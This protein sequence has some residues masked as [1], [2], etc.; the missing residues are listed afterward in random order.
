MGEPTDLYPDVFEELSARRRAGERV[1]LATVVSTRG[2][3]PRQAGAR[4]L[5]LADGSI[6]GTVGGGVRESEIAAVARELHHRGG[7]RLLAVDFEE[8]LAGGPAPV[9]GGHMEVFVEAI[10][11]LLR[12]VIA[13]AGHVGYFLHRMLALLEVRTVVV[14]P[15]AEFA[16]RER[17]P[18]AELRVVEFG[19]ALAGLALG[20]SDGVVIVT[21]GHEHDECVLR[22]AL[23]TSA[24]YLGMIGS[25]RKV[26]AVFE[27]LRSQ[28]V[29][30][31][32]LARVRAPVGLPIG[33]ETPAEIALA[34][35]AEIVATFRT[36]AI[37]A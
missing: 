16:S 10:D 21:K 2:S 1:V 3:T 37:G 12:V 24:G 8:G 29:G 22:Q 4:M 9:C 19:E 30:E 34:I 18:G 23:A 25:R 7:C 36:R 26:A 32:Q 17:F 35:A 31:E 20:A 11:P 13:G 27:R 15:R 5:V 28:G 14:D 33:A 6:R